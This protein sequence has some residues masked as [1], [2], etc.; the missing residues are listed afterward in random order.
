M[1]G[2]G[3]NHVHYSGDYKR[4]QRQRPALDSP[5]TWPRHPNLWSST[6][7]TAR[8]APLRNGMVFR[9]IAPGVGEGVGARVGEGVGAA[10][11]T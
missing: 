8:F 7:I 1:D 4:V 5:A 3:P 9:C 10:K 2:G 11:K 6:L